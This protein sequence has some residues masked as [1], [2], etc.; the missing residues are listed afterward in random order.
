[1]KG[2]AGKSEKVSSVAGHKG[3]SSG[4]KRMGNL[5]LWN[6]QGVQEKAAFNCVLKVRVFTQIKSF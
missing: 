5:A 2:R 6:N 1:M 3:R 4:A